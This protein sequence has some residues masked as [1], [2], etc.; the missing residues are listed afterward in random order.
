MAD[1]LEDESLLHF[2]LLKGAKRL[3]VVISDDLS[4]V[5]PTSDSPFL[6]SCDCPPNERTKGARG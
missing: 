6:I 4:I 2:G 3:G 5:V 1:N